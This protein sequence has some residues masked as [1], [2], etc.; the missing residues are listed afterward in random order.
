MKKLC[1]LFL[2]LLSSCSQ[3]EIGKTNDYVLPYPET[4]VRLMAYVRQYFYYRKQ[5]VI[6]RDS[7]F[8]YDRYPR[9][10]EGVDIGRGDQY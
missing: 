8:C 5:A 6:Q 3:F 10:K 7:S 1:I 2:I 9:L 4:Y